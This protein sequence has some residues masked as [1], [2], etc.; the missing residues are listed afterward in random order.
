MF[1]RFFSVKGKKKGVPDPESPKVPGRQ[2]RLEPEPDP[3]AY[4][5]EKV[6]AMAREMPER[7]SVWWACQSC[8]KVESKM[9]PHDVASMEAAEN[10][11]KTPNPATEEKLSAALQKQDFQGPGAWA[12][13]AASWSAKS[14]DVAGAASASGGGEALAAKA[15]AGAVKMAA[16]MAADKFTPPAFKAQTPEFNADL[17]SVDF[18]QTNG[19]VPVPSTPQENATMLKPFIELGHEI[20]SGSNGW[21]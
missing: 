5:S 16:A 21:S 1:G 10:W 7:K 19:E 18:P 12:A 14:A 3:E 6:D 17:P 15:V 11:V 13:Q 8:R 2:D 4:S 9:Q 20:E